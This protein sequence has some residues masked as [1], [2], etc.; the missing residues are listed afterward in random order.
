MLAGSTTKDN[1]SSPRQRNRD[2]SIRKQAEHSLSKK[3]S[4]KSPSRVISLKHF[5]L[6]VCDPVGPGTAI[7]DIAQVMAAR[8]VDAIMVADENGALI[9]IITDNDLTKYHTR[10]IRQP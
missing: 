8:R 7:A 3:T 5:Q 1:V 6:T 4:L 9:G 2:A 10:V